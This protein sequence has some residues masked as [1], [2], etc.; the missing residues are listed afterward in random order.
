MHSHTHSLTR[1]RTR[2]RSSLTPSLSPSRTQDAALLNVGLTWLRPSPAVRATAERAAARVS[3]KRAG[4][5][6]S[7][8]GLIFGVA[9]LFIFQLFG[10]PWVANLQN[11]AKAV[12]LF[13]WLFA[14][15]LA[16]SGGTLCGY[17]VIAFDDGTPSPRVDSYEFDVRAPVQALQALRALVE[18]A[19][20][21]IGPEQPLAPEERG[22]GGERARVSSGTGPGR[23]SEASTRCLGGVYGSAASICCWYGSP[24]SC[25]YFC[26]S[27]C[28]EKK[29]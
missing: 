11:T 21:L 9:T 4:I 13:L 20:V 10:T 23:A 27:P 8:L 18:P 29:T 3:Q 22:G 1:S 16:L 2:S 7:E 17:P 12:G 5:V 25:T 15:I 6:R 14:A 28:A 24:S 26:G 19:G